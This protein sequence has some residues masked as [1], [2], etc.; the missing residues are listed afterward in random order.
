M[1]YT[2][3]SDY[4]LT[5]DI[6]L[7]ADTYLAYLDAWEHHV[8]SL[9]DDY[10]REKAL[11]GPDTATRAKVVWQVKIWPATASFIKNI[12][13]P[14]AYPSTWQYLTNQWQS[15]NRGHLQALV[16]P[17]SGDQT[18]PCITPPQSGYRGQENQLYRVEIHQGGTPDRATFK[19][20]RDNGSV[21]TEWKD[22]EGN[23][24]IVGRTRGFAEGQWVELTDDTRE[25]RGQRGVLVQVMITNGV[26][27][28]ID[29]NSTAESIDR[30]STFVNPKVR[31]WDHHDTD[32]IKLTNDNAIAVQEGKP[33]DLEDGIQIQFIPSGA[34]D[35]NQYRTGDYWLIPARTATGN[36]EWPAVRDAQGKLIPATQPP[37]GVKHHYAP[38]WI[39]TVAADGSVTAND[40]ADDLRR[41]FKPLWTL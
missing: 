4:L 33:I 20:S 38:L 32:T 6:K 12:T 3:Q 10:V 35:P 22:K 13:N 16:K 25:L 5:D 15:E 11:G 31:R 9:E 28:T 18:D 37:H 2:A 17:L 34:S 39:I 7:K 24:L 40:P 27:L 29:P 41:K 30:L 14:G 21:V 1:R 26:T 8:S 23:E 19:W 36:I